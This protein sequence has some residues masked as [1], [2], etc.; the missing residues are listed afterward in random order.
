MAGA[1]DRPHDRP[2]RKIIRR[3][4]PARDWNATSSAKRGGRRCISTG[5]MGKIIADIRRRLAG[6]DAGRRRTSTVGKTARRTGRRRCARSFS[7]RRGYDL[8][9]F[10]PAMTGRVVDSLEVIGA[11]SVGFATDGFRAGGREL[12]RARSA[13]WRNEHGLRLSIEAYGE[14]VR[15]HDVRRPGR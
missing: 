4:L 7:K 10:L 15:R 6:Q 11:V 1:A 14:P 13:S 5:L 2:A 8:L 9:P 12:R 3:R